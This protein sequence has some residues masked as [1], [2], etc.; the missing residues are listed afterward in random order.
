VK[1][2]M[3]DPTQFSSLVGDIKQK[4]ILSPKFWFFTEIL[5]FWP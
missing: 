5:F 3:L 1:Q 4:R 2:L